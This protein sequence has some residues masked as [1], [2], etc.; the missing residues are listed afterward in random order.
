MARPI[1]FDSPR[2]DPKREL[3]R[4]LEEAPADHAAALLNAYELLQV[5]HDKNMLDIARGL[6]G[7]S[8]TVLDIA[9]KGAIRPESVN[10]MRNLIVLFNLIGSIDP[11]TMNRFTSAIPDAVYT[12]SNQTKPPGL[13]NLIK[14]S[15]F[16]G[17]FR[18]GL[19]AMIGVLRGVGRGVGK[20]ASHKEGGD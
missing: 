9:V 17:D 4:K 14:G 18:R 1:A 15:I 12:S 19:G 2:L 11:G 3:H 20:P 16:D 5:L 7:S 6:V 8:E 10:A 13:W